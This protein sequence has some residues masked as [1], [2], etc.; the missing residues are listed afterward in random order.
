MRGHLFY[1]HHITKKIQA[2]NVD[3]QIVNESVSE[4]SES[5]DDNDHLKFY[6]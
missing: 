2:L 1:Q 6:L 3:A 5:D 4:F